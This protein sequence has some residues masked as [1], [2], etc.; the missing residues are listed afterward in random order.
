MFAGDYRRGVEVYR[1]SSEILTDG[2]ELQRFG[3]PALPGV[4]SRAW[5]GY[6]LACLGDFSGGVAMAEE[7]LR[8]AEAAH[9]PYSI[10]VAVQGVG[11]PYVVQGNLPSALLWLERAVDIDRAGSFAVLRVLCQIFL[12]RTLSLAG[13]HREAVKMLEDGV[14]YGEAIQFAA[15]RAL[16]LAW[17][18]DAHRRDGQ[19]AHAVATIDQAVQ[20]TR[21]PGQRA[22]EVEVLLAV[23]ALHTSSGSPD[24]D[25]ARSAAQQALSLADGLGAR[26]LVARAYLALGHVSRQTG[27]SVQAAEN[28]ARAAAM[29]TEMGMSYWLEQSNP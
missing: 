9:H 5:L 21:A 27:A 18:G 16:S 25:A 2:L 10:A 4:I 19:V 3:M 24:L 29:F 14:A 20:A 26:P 22:G 12:G 1:R 28:L 7:A 11:F 17:L 23:A 6:G 13:R 15:F 8:V